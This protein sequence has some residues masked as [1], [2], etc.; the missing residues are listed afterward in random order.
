MGQPYQR[1]SDGMWCVSIELPGT[2]TKRRRKVI[3]R[4]RKADVIDAARDA[5]KELARTGDLPTASPTLAGWLDGWIDR[6]AKSRLKPRTAADYRSVIALYLAPSI[7]RVRLDKL[8]PDHVQRMHDYVTGELGLS[9]TTALKAHRVLAKALTDAERA[10]K[11]QRNVATLLDAPTRAF[12]PRPAL[13]ADEA[14]ALLR[15]VAGTPAAARWGVALLAG[16]RQGEALGLTRDAVDLEQGVITVSWQLQRLAW[17]HGC[18]KPCGS[19]PARCPER[20]VTIPPDQEATRVHGGLWLTR[21]KSRTGWR[22]V[23][24]A[25]PLLVELAR[26]LDGAP[27]GPHGLIFT[28]TTAAGVLRAMDPSPDA[29]AW[30]AACRAAGIRD[31]PLHSARH[32]CSTLLAFLGVDEHIRMQILGHSSATVTRAYTHVTTEDAR[33]GMRA[34]GRLLVE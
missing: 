23:P 17:E 7:G 21:P 25:P 20:T 11:V 33:E 32:T 26:H 1:A 12:R 4:A 31:V 24:I 22:Q 29:K 2:G 28:R 9:S 18:A 14:V 3:V 34:L 16:L 10:G 27:A 13:S 6:R 8:T 5:R 19:S 15:S 30:D